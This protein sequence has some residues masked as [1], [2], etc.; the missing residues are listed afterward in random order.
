MHRPPKWVL[1]K[2]IILK[3]RNNKYIFKYISE[4]K[5]NWRKNIIS[6][7]ESRRYTCIK[8]INNVKI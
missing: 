4:S 7:I 3:E 2:N 8:D 5:M 6:I 1:D